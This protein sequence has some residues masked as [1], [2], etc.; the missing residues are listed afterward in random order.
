MVQ[1]EEVRNTFEFVVIAGARAHQ[2]LRGC[3][4]RT[5]GSQKAAKLAA[6]EVKQGHVRRIP[7]AKEPV[8]AG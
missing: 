4:P 2:L 8:D 3:L 1:R 7:S 5:V 6:L